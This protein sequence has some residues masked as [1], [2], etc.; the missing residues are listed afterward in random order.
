MTPGFA[1]VEILYPSIRQSP[2]KVRRRRQS[3]GDCWD[4]LRSLESGLQSTTLSE[5]GWVGLVGAVALVALD[6]RVCM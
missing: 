2:T 4:V 3:T 1:Q 5:T 6:G